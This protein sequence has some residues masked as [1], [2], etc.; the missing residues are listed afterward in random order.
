LVFDEL[1]D[2]RKVLNKLVEAGRNTE[3]DLKA[4][5]RL[6]VELSVSPAARRVLADMPRDLLAFLDVAECV[7][8]EAPADAVLP[9]KPLELGE[10]RVTTLAK[11]ERCWLYRVQTSNPSSDVCLCERCRVAV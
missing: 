2:V 11:C 1:H 4:T 10:V 7:V 8:V 5:A 3:G 6:S 9:A